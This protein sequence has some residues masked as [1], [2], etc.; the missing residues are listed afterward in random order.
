MKSHVIFAIFKRN[1]FSYFSNPIGYVFI[2]VFVAL[3]G[4]AAFWPNEFFASNLANLDQLS[5]Y[6]PWI[7]LVFIPAITMSI[8]ADERRQGTDELLLTIPASD[9][10]VVMGKYLGAL[11]IYTSALAFSLLCNFI[12]LTLLGQP[13][14]GL[15]FSTYL[16]YWIVG[17]A[18]LSVG[19]VASF[20]TGNL[21]VGF[22]FGALFNSPLVIATYADV[23]LPTQIYPRTLLYDIL[24]ESLRGA[25]PALSVKAWSLSEQFRDFGHGVV[26]LPSIAYFL[27]ITAVMLYLSMV[28]IGRRHWQGGAQ[29]NK[30]GWHYTLRAVALLVACVGLV[31]VLNRSGVRAD[32][33]SERLNSL[34]PQTVKLITGLDAKKPVRIEAYVSPEMP[35]SYVQTRAT[36]VSVLRE[37][38]ARSGGKISVQVY[39]TQPLSDEA[40][41]A[42]KLYGIT[43]RQVAS[44][45]TAEVKLEEI[46]IG[47]AVTAGLEKVVIPFVDRGIP[48]EYEVAR[49]VATVNGQKRKTL[50]VLRTDAQLLSGPESFMSGGGRNQPIIEELQK[51][52]DVKEV[53]PDQPITEKYDV[54]LAAQPSTLT[55][56]QMDNFIAAVEHGQPTAIFEDPY[57]VLFQGVTASDAPRMPQ[58]NNMM[59]MFGG[60]QPPQPKGDMNRLWSMLGV[61]Y[62]A[63]QVVWQDYNP[64]PRHQWLP[65]ECVF[66]E[67]A[68]SGRDVFDQ[69]D[70]ISSGL[71][72]LLFVCPGSFTHQNRSNGLTFHELAR[73]GGRT[74]IVK[75]SELP[76][77]DPRDP[78]GRTSTFPP[79]PRRRQRP[80][81]FEYAL[82]VHLQGT[83]K[84][85]AVPMSDAEPKA[86]EKKADDK[87]DDAAKKDE[88]KINVVL[89]GD[90]DVLGSDFFGLRARGDNPEGDGFLT[91]VDNVTFVL[92]T[93]DVL[94]GDD[95][96]VE[97]RKHRPKYRTLSTIENVTEDARKK[98]IKDAE[99]FVEARDK[100][101]KE[102]QS[103]LDA[104]VAKRSNRKDLDP[105]RA[106]QELQ[107][108]K[109]A[110]QNRV[111]TQIAQEEKKFD[112]KKKEIER[113]LALDIRAVHNRYKLGSIIIPPILPM[114]IGLGVFFYR[115]A[116]EREGVSRERLR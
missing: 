53:N 19:M 51:Q 59:A 35:E 97:I 63:P 25:Q 64:Y 62:D 38:E 69:K 37:F 85:D 13:D 55:P 29:G 8:W 72:Q 57:P 106:A 90:I 16:G 70:P 98:A 31:V 2:C 5:R 94:A 93:L 91:N 6:M 42:E 12:T 21:T 1:F 60:Q 81:G 87:K 82:A 76:N 103:G 45:T 9:F 84:S 41:R 116:Q 89:V 30:L 14:L 83:L 65:P 27:G 17:L 101:I 18:M 105:R 110:A 54:L 15:F 40:D 33:S 71:Q 108:Y 49:S 23:I 48:V 102:A 113:E 7:L 88:H 34:T 58:Q 115:R 114:V 11:A 28:L 77:R 73:T 96:F 46:Y 80:T 20:L 50:G 39:D 66:V 104:E 26:S 95:R 56:P 86:D 107:M 111:N 4:L 10:D 32:I 109:V 44:Q 67:R 52:Y 43:A 3:S 47:M 112:Q 75:Y 78:F 74:G 99:A 36:F 100:A 22:V 92:N 24:P 79:N 68:A 61:G